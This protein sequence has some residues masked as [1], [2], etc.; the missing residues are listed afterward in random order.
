MKGITNCSVCKSKLDA[1]A[2]NTELNKYYPF[3]S[4]KCQN[5]D[6]GNWVFENYRV[7]SSE[8]VVESEDRGGGFEDEDSY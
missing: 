7:P 8:V 5:K 4:K 6:L 2:I 3:C 1:E